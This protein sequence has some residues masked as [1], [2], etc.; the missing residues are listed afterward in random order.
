MQ[1]NQPSSRTTAP[2]PF[3]TPQFPEVGIIGLVPDAWESPWQPRHHVLSRLAEWFHLVWAEPAHEW[4]TPRH[5]HMPEAMPSSTLDVYTPEWWL[6]K[7]YRPRWFATHLD[8]VRI[9]Q[10][11]KRL[12]KK[13]C[14]QI[15]LYLWRPEQAYAL[16]V[17]HYDMTCYHL[18]DEY[19]FSAVEQPISPQEY[20]LLKRVNQVIVHSVGLFEKKG[21]INPNSILIPNGVDFTGFCTP[22]AEPPDLA[23]IPQPRV[24][25]IGYLKPQINFQ[26]LLNLAQRHHEWSFVFVG[27]RGHLGKEDLLLINRLSAFPNVHF[28]GGKPVKALPAYAQGMNVSIMPY[29]VNDYTKYI[30]PMKLHEYLATGRPVVGSPIRSLQQFQ[31]IVALAATDEEWSQALSAALCQEAMS[32]DIVAR[33]RKMASQYDWSVLVACIAQRI[34]DTLGKTRDATLHL[35]T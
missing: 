29:K 28:L 3:S 1:S 13:G 6:P 16:D 11:Y 9:K 30:F 33:R 15:V 2:P 5:D 35:P 19:S 12:K 23:P 14:Q 24:G 21:H 7:V 25:H 17:L 34:C 20:A 27:P 32:A 26:L 4:R 31:D 10:A 22:V 8:H 18:D